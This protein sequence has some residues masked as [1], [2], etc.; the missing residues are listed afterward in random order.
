ML[1]V[2][3]ACVLRLLACFVCWRVSFAGGFRLLTGF[4]CKR[5][6]FAGAFRCRFWFFLWRVSVSCRWHRPPFPPSSHCTAAD[7]RRRSWSCRVSVARS[8]RV[9]LVG[10]GRF[11]YYV[12][13]GKGEAPQRELV[14]SSFVC[15]GTP[16]P[17]V[18]VGTPFRPSMSFLWHPGSPLE[19]TDHVDHRHGSVGVELLP[20]GPA[21]P[22]VGLHH[23]ALLDG[24]A[25]P[26]ARPQ[27]H[28]TRTC[29]SGGAWRAA[30][31][32]EG[33]SSPF[34]KIKFNQISSGFSRPATTG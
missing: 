17:F 23:R 13:F 5:V 12:L 7:Q 24:R 6:S 19:L 4:V 18:C 8:S 11:F 16:F 31:C 34:F 21:H 20:V 14:S 30:C 29:E 15:V 3:F 25:A 1:C 9:P 22:A 27:L 28:P 10:G 33:S 32:L 2:S 26:P